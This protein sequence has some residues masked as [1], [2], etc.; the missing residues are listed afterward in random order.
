[1]AVDAVI[2]GLVGGALLVLVPL[3]ALSWMSRK[4]GQ[5]GQIDGELRACPD[6]LNCV[7]SEH[8][9]ARA[10]VAPLAFTCAPDT[11]WQAVQ[12]ALR[13]L[14]GRLQ[15]QGGSYLHATFTTRVFRFKDDLEL[16]LDRRRSVI[17]VR[18]ASRVGY[19][20]LG[21]NRRRVERLRA[22]FNEQLHHGREAV[23]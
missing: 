7:C 12:D 18:S 3:A 8:R 14:G 20:D 16:R 21:V 6:S 23:G 5:T 19:S 15:Q 13:I 2:Y 9:Q 22:V 1:M 10:F 4:H 11:A 17:Q